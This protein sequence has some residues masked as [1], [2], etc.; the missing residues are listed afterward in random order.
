L[1]NELKLAHGIPGIKLRAFSC[2]YFASFHRPLHCQNPKTTLICQDYL[3]IVCCSFYISQIL[4]VKWDVELRLW[5]WAQ[6]C[7]STVAMGPY[8]FGR[9]H[10]LFHPLSLKQEV[11]VWPHIATS[12]EIVTIQ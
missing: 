11:L 1:S 12:I 10:P 3:Q 7:S 4:V 2:Y 8:L 5:R 6:I 9:Y